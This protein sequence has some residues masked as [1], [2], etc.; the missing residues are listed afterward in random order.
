VDVAP[1]FSRPSGT[2]VARD[3][4]CFGLTLGLTLLVLGVVAPW[5][6][7]LS[8]SLEPA[9]GDAFG[10]FV[11]HWG[12]KPASLL[13][14]AAAFALTTKSYRA[15]HPLVARCSAAVLSQVLLHPAL[16]TN[17]LKLLSGRPRPVALGPAGEGFVHFFSMSPGFGD[18]SFP[19]GHVAVA[20]LL[21]PCALLLWR[22]GRLRESVAVAVA[23][24]VWSGAVAYGRVRF[25]AHF[26]TDVLF[27][28]GIGVALAPVSLRLGELLL[29][30]LAAREARPTD[31]AT[32]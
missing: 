9:R 10:A 22:E 31:A 21:A 20:M 27:S 19:S 11:Q 3:L 30:R 4:A 8:L 2:S 23:T 18:F 17:L 15:V 26:P 14:V 28:I 13:V 1:T 29:A 24:A 7:S 12:R 16:L 6:L 5:D 32:A 25:G